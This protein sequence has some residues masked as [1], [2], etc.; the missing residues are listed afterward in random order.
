LPCIL[1]DHTADKL[2]RTSSGRATLT[3]PANFPDSGFNSLV[4]SRSA[5]SFPPR[6]QPLYSQRDIGF[7][8]ATSILGPFGISP[9]YLRTVGGS[10]KNLIE[11]ANEISKLYS[12]ERD[13]YRL[14]GSFV[15]SEFCFC[16][17]N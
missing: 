9:A 13:G 2:R 8:L 11:V 7:S 3:P 4:V 5:I 17:G 6:T 15:V 16:S 1:P 10:Q 12:D 14:W